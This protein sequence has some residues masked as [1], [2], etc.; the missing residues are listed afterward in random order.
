MVENYDYWD[1]EDLEDDE[2]GCCDECGCYHSH[3][4]FCSCYD[5][6]YYPDKDF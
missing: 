1:D 3:F 6:N 5:P 4:K 2:G